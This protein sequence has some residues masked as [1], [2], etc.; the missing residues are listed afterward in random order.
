RL[1]L[2][3]QDDCLRILELSLLTHYRGHGIGT[4]ILRSLLNEAHGGKVPVRLQVERESP[5]L[6]LYLRHGFRPVGQHGHH[7]ELE[8]KPDLRKREI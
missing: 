2:D 7:L 6:R 5:A 4:D 8:W 3:R 1:Y